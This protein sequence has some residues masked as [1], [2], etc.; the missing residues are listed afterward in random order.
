M[1]E[2]RCRTSQ[3]VL[4]Y[5]D[6]LEDG[7]SATFVSCVAT[8]YSLPT[9]H[10]MSRSTDYEVRRAAVLALGMLGGGESI[11]VVGRRLADTDRCVRLVAEMAFSG[12]TLREMGG[13]SG[14]EL[15]GVRRHL[16]GHRYRRA[17]EQL[18]RILHDWPRFADAW[19]LRAIALSQMRRYRASMK[20]AKQAVRW[21]QYH[22]SALSLIAR[23]H[24]ELEQPTLALAFFYRSLRINPS[25]A[26]VRSYVEVLAHRRRLNR[27]DS[28]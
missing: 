25:Q 4:W 15:D 27:D 21:N 24:L 19:H 18:D 20:A 3:L 16:D 17:I 12:L 22:F 6:Y 23:C 13:A 5:R 9:L 10:R 11:E 26:W 28:V 8:R 2:Q 7:K 1:N 14:R